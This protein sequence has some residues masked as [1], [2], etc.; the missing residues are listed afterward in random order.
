MFVSLVNMWGPHSHLGRISTS[1]LIVDACLVACSKNRCPQGCT[2]PFS[3][4]K[5]RNGPLM[6]MINKRWLYYS[7]EIKSI[8]KQPCMGYNM[9]AT[10]NTKAGQCSNKLIQ[11]STY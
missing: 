10:R 5:N 3:G 1:L 2:L 8:L 7:A 4:E 6:T 11:T 9:K